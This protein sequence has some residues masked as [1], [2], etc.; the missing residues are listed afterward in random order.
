MDR[1]RAG[2]TFLVTFLF[3]AV[4]HP[5]TS[6]EST[7]STPCVRAH[8]YK[9]NLYERTPVWEH[10][11]MTANSVWERTVYESTPCVIAQPYESTICMTAHLYE[12]TICMTAHPAW[13]HNCMTAYPVRLA[14]TE[15]ETLRGRADKSLARPTSRCHRTELIVSL[16][17]GVCSCAELQVFSCYRG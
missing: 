10:T 8:P 16:A 12:S 2:R 17:R 15:W 4:F 7:E 1:N 13:E 9:S 11:C 14:C 6:E 3:N 5:T